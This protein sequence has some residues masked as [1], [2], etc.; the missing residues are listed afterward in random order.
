MRRTLALAILGAVMASPSLA[1]AEAKE[2]RV[3]HSIVIDAPADAV[4]AVAGD[5]VGLNKWYPPIEASKL[6]LG[7]NNE[8][9][10][11]RLLTRRNGTKVEEKLID[12]EPWNRSLTYTYAEGDPI[13]SDYFATLTVRP[14]PD[15]KSLVEWKARF[16]RLA[17]WTDNPPPGQDDETPTKALNAGYKLGLENLKRMLESR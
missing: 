4:W 14:L 17:Y 16:K 5:F 3:E 9:G 12:Y 11:I 13:S 8:V 2:Q 15:G 7:R 10:A 1:Q 6:V